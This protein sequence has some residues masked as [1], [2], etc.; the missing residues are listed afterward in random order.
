VGQSSHFNDAATDIASGIPRILF[1][2][3]A[4]FFPI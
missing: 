3:V 2:Y 1:R 4:S